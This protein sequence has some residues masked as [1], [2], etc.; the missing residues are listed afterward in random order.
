[1]GKPEKAFSRYIN[2]V[3]DF[4][5]QSAPRSPQNIVWFTRSAFGAAALKEREK[6]YPEAVQIYRRVVEA[7]VPAA[8]E[9]AKRIEKI[10]KE[11]WLLFEQ[12]KEKNHVGTDY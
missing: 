7:Q 4:I 6:A 9:A 3:Y 8:T 12:A 11:N 5:N 10:K 1:M 2:V